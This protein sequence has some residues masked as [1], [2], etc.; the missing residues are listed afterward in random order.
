VQEGSAGWK[1]RM[2]MGEKGWLDGCWMD[3]PSRGIFILVLG[4]LFIYFCFLLLLL[5]Q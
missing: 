5:V 2:R 3:G 1:G 4:F